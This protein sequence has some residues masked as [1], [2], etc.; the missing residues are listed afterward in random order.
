MIPDTLN[1]AAD[2]NVVQ[3]IAVVAQAV[4]VIVGVVITWCA[5]GGKK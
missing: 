4:M 2:S 1:A 5:K 3:Q